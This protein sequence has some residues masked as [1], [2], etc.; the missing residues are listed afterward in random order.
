MQKY[1][2]SWAIWKTFLVQVVAGDCGGDQ[3]FFWNDIFGV[4]KFLGGQIFWSHLL[5]WKAAHL[6]RR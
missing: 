4:S 1:L 5:E 3:Q 2:S 6:H